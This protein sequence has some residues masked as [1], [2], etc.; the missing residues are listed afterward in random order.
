MDLLHSICFVNENTGYVVGA[1]GRVLKTV[2]GGDS[3]VSLNIGTYSE[4][5]QVQCFGDTVYISMDTCLFKSINGGLNW[6]PII[7]KNSYS[8]RSISFINNMIGYILDNNC[9]KKTLDGGLSWYTLPCS[10]SG[11][12]C[13][14]FLSENVGFLVGNNEKV[15]KTIDSGITWA[16][17]ISTVSYPLDYIYFVNDT[18]GFIHSW[19]TI[20]KTIDSGETWINL[21]LPFECNASLFI[22]EDVGFANQYA[23]KIHRTSDGGLTWDCYTWFSET[24]GGR[25]FYAVSD[26][27]IYCV[28]SNGSILKTTNGGD[29]S[30]T[31]INKNNF[32]SKKDF[33]LYPN[34]AQESVMIET[35]EEIINI[36]CYN[37]MGELFLKTQE[38]TINTSCFSSGIYIVNVET[39]NGISSQKLIIEK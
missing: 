9:I 35:T 27:E 8:Y 2:D 21:G 24:A 3:W 25:D 36:S 31:S 30:S 16:P 19:N 5:K 10:Y 11:I 17:K 39:K 4:L 7:S 13:I 22:S 14:Y 26:L 37:L 29:C 12:S 18:V 20:L 15:Y 32:S 33:S 23:H 28:G 1:S 6:T 38:K 34:P